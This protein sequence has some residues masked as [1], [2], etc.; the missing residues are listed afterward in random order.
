[1]QFDL[2]NR[3]LMLEEKIGQIKEQNEWLEIRI[4][5]LEIGKKP[6]TKNRCN[7]VTKANKS[8]NQEEEEVVNTKVRIE[9]LIDVID[10]F[11]VRCSPTASRM[12][13]THGETGKNAPIDVATIVRRTSG[14]VHSKASQR[15]P[16]YRYKRQ[17]RRPN[18]DSG[19]SSSKF[20][21]KS[22]SVLEEVSHFCCDS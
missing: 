4:T 13:I 1:M 9:L 21:L 5:H 14:S 18:C 15:I 12:G 3:V 17:E 2:Q 6:K 8:I 16:R 7:S 11:T 20:T 19:W 10:F 22:Y